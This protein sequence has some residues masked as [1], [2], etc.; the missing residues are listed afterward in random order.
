MPL[1]RKKAQNT[2]NLFWQ[3]NNNLTWKQWQSS[4]SEENKRNKHWPCREQSL[5]PQWCC[6][7]LSQLLYF[8]F[9]PR[10]SRGHGYPT[11]SPGA[12]WEGS[13]ACRTHLTLFAPTSA[14]ILCVLTHFVW[15]MLSNADTISCP[16]DTLCAQ[17]YFPNEDFFPKEGQLQQSRTNVDGISAELH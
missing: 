1:I 7:C 12:G 11:S 9:A 13:S 8:L 4:V 6:R 17:I 16:F 3:R 15:S 5:Y 14:H 10:D 2:G